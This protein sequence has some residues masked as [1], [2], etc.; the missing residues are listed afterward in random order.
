M[1]GKIKTVILTEVNTDKKEIFVIKDS[2]NIKGIVIDYI[3]IKEQGN[4]ILIEIQKDE[5][6]L[7]KEEIE[8][9][10]SDE[11][12][13]IITLSELYD[14]LEIYCLNYKIKER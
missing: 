6:I 11:N 10:L 5:V 13:R 12:S 2:N 9:L 1:L 14:M 4:V 8:E 7:N 3:F